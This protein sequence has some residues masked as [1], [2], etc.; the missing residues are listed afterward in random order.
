M[1]Q[2]ALLEELG[3]YDQ[4]AELHLS[5][6]HTLEAIAAFVK[7]TNNPE[8]AKRASKCVLDGLWQWLSL[9]VD[10]ASEPVKANVT[11]QELL[12]QLDQLDI[13]H[14]EEEMRDEVCSRRTSRY[15]FGKV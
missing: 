1:S 12:R 15:L 5:Q 11:L 13:T 6:G 14:I 8:S 4:L 9:G 7:D 3:Y 10:T 2:A